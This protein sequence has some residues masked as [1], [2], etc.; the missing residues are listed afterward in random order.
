ML[1]DLLLLKFE[2]F[3]PLYFFKCRTTKLTVEIDWQTSLK[4][5]HAHFSWLVK[6]QNWLSS[7]SKCFQD[8]SGCFIEL[9]SHVQE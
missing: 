2:S 5:V 3:F 9:A 4:K 8:L 7:I 1:F 6:A